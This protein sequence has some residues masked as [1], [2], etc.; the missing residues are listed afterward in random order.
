MSVCVCVCDQSDRDIFNKKEA[1]PMHSWI[2]KLSKKFIGASIV[3]KEPKMCKIDKKKK[4]NYTK[5]PL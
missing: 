5:K 4:T 2:K 1:T 3:N